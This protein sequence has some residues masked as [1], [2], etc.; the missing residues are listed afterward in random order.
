MFKT[1]GNFLFKYRSYTPLP[2]VA[3]MLIFAGPTLP[4]MITGFLIAALGETIRLLS[5][6]Y[7]GSETRTTEAVGGSNL[8][9]QG[10]YGIV[11]NPLYIGNIM[12]YT[13]IG[14]MSNALFPYLQIAGLIFFTF[15]Y[16]CIILNEEEYLATAFKEKFKI[17]TETTGR[18]FPTFKK[19]PDSIKSNLP[20][21]LNSGIVS[22]KRT[23]QAFIFLTAFIITK[24]ILNIYF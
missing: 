18:F 4:L 15:Q 1:I 3:L 14:I 5:V 20:F 21:D 8:V 13:G 7:A 12:I 23:L 16:Y 6:S 2:F 10:P 9:T 22:E 11:R 17:Y 24:Y 19:I